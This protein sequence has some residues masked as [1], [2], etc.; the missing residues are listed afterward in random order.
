MRITHHKLLLETA[1][2]MFLEG[3]SLADVHAFWLKNGIKNKNTRNE[4]ISESYKQI[5]ETHKPT[6]LLL[7]Q[8]HLLIYKKLIE[9]YKNSTQPFE[10]K[11]LL[12]CLADRAK[13]CSL[14]K[15]NEQLASIKQEPLEVVI[16]DLCTVDKPL[17]SPTTGEP[18]VVVQAADPF[19]SLP[20]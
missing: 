14:D 6:R 20:N 17:I 4:Y 11:L 7:Y 18:A 2:Q 1:T 9:K 5:E 12:T 3:S 13:L 19:A 10:Q 8:E 15:L 16:T